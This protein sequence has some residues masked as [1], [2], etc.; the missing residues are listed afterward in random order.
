[1]L[2]QLRFHQ[3]NVITV[4]D[5]HCVLTY[6][7]YYEVSPLSKFSQKPIPNFIYT[8]NYE[9]FLSLFNL[10]FSKYLF[11]FCICETLRLYRKTSLCLFQILFSLCY[12]LWIFHQKLFQL[13]TSG[14]CVILKKISLYQD[15][16]LKAQ[17]L[18]YLKAF[19]FLHFAMFCFVLGHAA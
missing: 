19:M 16:F 11:F 12:Y 17:L 5:P 7:E 10:Y 3:P 8:F 4:Y 18:F 14:F 13:P 9:Y 2:Y 6:T 15:Y 1:M